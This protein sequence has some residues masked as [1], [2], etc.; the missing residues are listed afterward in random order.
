MPNNVEVTVEP[1]DRL[2][3]VGDMH[4]C[5]EALI[6]MFLGNQNLSIEPL[7]FPG[8][9]SSDGFRNV[10]M[11]NGDMVDRGG[12]GYQIIFALCLFIIVDNT[13]LYI[14]RGNHES[15]MFGMSLQPGM[16]HKF[17]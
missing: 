7:G 5:F 11:I 1:T 3:L 16:G 8:D 10:Y 14:N 6:H 17:M 12:S 9:I 4:G 15:E 2:I 13:A